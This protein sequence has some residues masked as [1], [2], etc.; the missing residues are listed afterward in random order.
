MN[1]DICG[2]EEGELHKYFWCIR[3]TCPFCGDKMVSC[4]CIYDMTDLRN[5]L[6]YQEKYDHLSREVYRNGPPD[7]YIVIWKDLVLK[8]GRIPFTANDI[9]EPMRSPTSET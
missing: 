1:C 3:E 9:P 5:P 8:K 7:R 2:A 4:D 6:K